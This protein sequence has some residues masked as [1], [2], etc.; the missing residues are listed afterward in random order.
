MKRLFGFYLAMMKLSLLNTFQYRLQMAFY[1][2][3]N[4]A[5]P[6]IYLVVWSTIARAQGGQVGG[7]TAE[8]GRA[9]CRERVSLHV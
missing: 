3:T 1:M 2:I 4:F 9:S 7:Y 5:E 6:V 8:I